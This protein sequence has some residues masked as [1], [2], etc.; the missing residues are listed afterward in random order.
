MKWESIFFL[1]DDVAITSFQLDKAYNLL[2][3]RDVSIVGFNARHFPDN[4]VAMHIHR[5]LHDSIDSF[6][7]TGAMAVKTNSPFVSF[8]PHIYNEDWLFLLIYRLLGEG[9]IIWA[10][11]I[12]QKPYNPYKYASRATSEA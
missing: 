1:D 3:T 9:N 8:F 12:K 5:W 10:G 7:G 4:S 11:T 6:L 2:Q